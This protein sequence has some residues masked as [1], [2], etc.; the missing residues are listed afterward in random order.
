MLDDLIAERK[1]KLE[2]LRAAGH[3]PY[4]AT[5]RR[6]HTI[7]EVHKSFDRLAKDAA[8]LVITGRVV[9]LRDQGSLIFLDVQDESGRLQVILRKDRLADFD[10]IKDTITIGDFAEAKG[11]S[12]RTQ[13]GEESIEAVAFRV[14]AKS[15]RPLPDQYYGLEDSE[16]RLRKRYLDILA[17]NDVRALFEKKTLFWDACR[18]ILLREKFFEV[19]TPILE[20]TPGGADAEPFITH[21]KALDTDFYLRISLEIPLKKLLV[22]GYEKVFEIGRVF[23]N[24]G[25]DREHLQEYTQMECYA[26]YWD[27]EKMM[28]FV[29]AMYKDVVRKTTGATET[30]RGEES[31]SWDVAWPRLDY[32]EFFH[33][34][35]GMDLASATDEELLRKAKE[36]DSDALPSSGRGRLIDAIYKKAVRPT[37]IAPCFLVNHPIEISPLAKENP[38]HKGRVLRFQ[39]IA[40]GTELGNGWAEL[41]D[42]LD[43][44]RRLEEQMKLREAGDTEAQRL[45]EDFLEAM[46]YGMP[47]AA[48]FGLSERLFAVLMDKPM[49]EVVIF[50]PMRP[51]E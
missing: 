45:D 15:L 50:P 48:G 13:K 38:G 42:P 36:L 31:I 28:A 19:E 22:A 16:T 47:P 46:E 2:K 35:T 6:T 49:R 21:H 1:K 20:V 12:L 44:R 9:G 24:E 43:Q 4:P 7:S 23:R 18:E 14:I 33:S 29:E 3:D 51:K 8:P 30:R 25:I 40:A 17:H 41:N 34:K 32:S 27:H 10:L 37:L 26:A 5:V 39:V 11:A